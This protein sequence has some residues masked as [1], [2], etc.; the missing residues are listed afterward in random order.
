M[1]E[2]TGN[3]ET[4][5]FEDLRF[6]NDTSIRLE[7]IIREIIECAPDHELYSFSDLLNFYSAQLRKEYYNRK[8]GENKQKYTDC[9]G[10]A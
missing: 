6:Y 2:M 3:F 10:H 4:E 5:N 1:E 7:K 9:G 8:Y